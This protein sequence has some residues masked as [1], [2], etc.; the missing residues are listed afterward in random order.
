MSLLIGVQFTLR[1][2]NRN[3]VVSDTAVS[4]CHDLPTGTADIGLL[5]NK[6]ASLNMARRTC[7]R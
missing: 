3:M 4:V 2:P 5:Q 1:P 6:I 7:S